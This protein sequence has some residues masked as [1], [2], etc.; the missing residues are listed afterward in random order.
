[1]RQ[2]DLNSQ[3]WH[4]LPPPIKT[5]IPRKEI[6]MTILYK[7][8]LIVARQQT[9]AKLPI[10]AHP[11]NTGFDSTVAACLKSGLDTRPLISVEAEYMYNSQFT[12]WEGNV[13]KAD[14]YE[15]KEQPPPCLRTRLKSKTVA[16]NNWDRIEDHS[17]KQLEISSQHAGIKIK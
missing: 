15:T 8:Y 10:N 3:W 16:R 9:Q 4:Y 1:M 11:A 6:I 12:T 14:P 13:Y 7:L 5:S 17:Y 2:P